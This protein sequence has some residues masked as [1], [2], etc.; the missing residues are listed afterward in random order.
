MKKAL[1]IILA[2]ALFSMVIVSCATPNVADSGTPAPEKSITLSGKDPLK[3]AIKIAWI[4]MST[5]GQ[6][7]TIVYQAEDE[8]TMAYPDVTIQN[9]DAQFNPQTQITLVNECVAQGFD[10]ILMECAD[11]TAVGPSIA[12]AEAAGVAVI[13]VNLNCDVVHSLYVKMD[14]YSGGWVSAEAL[15][16]MM[17]GKGNYLVL[18]VPAFQAA[19]TTFGKGFM[20]YCDANTDMALLEYVNLAGNAQEDAYNVMRDMLTKYDN[21]DAVYAP[22]DN[23]GLGIVQAINEAGRQGDNILVWGTDL[24]PGGIEAVQSGVLAGSCWSDR[25]SSLYAAFTYA[26]ALAQ[27]GATAGVLG[28]A[29]TPS[30]YVRFIAVTK[31][32]VDEVVP[33]T[34]WPGY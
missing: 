12:A 4:P 1:A 31:A 5:A 9:F 7:N 30:I 15:A 29:A 28:L 16:K 10:A 11:S 2:L 19:S 6:V 3:D 14:S 24:Q 20:E 8:I 26:I 27:S 18:D 23:Y 25:F 32:N 33:F 13:T 21:I 22:D 34:R 17:G